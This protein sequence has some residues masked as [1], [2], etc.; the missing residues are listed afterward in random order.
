MKETVTAGFQTVTPMLMFGADQSRA[1]IRIPSIKGAL[2]FWYRAVDPHYWKHEPQ[3]FGSG[4]EKGGQSR[5]LMRLKTISQP[6]KYEK[7]WRKGVGYSYLSFSIKKNREPISVGTSFEISFY[8]RGH[9]D[10]HGNEEDWKRLMA[11]VWL[12]GHMGGLGSRSR[13]G[14]GSLTLKSIDPKSSVSEPFSL[15]LI[16]RQKKPHE[17]MHAFQSGMDQIQGWL[18]KRSTEP[19]HTVLDG[20][21]T[22]HLH[23]HGYHDWKLAM[24]ELGKTLKD[25]REKE[26]DREI[27]GRK[28]WSKGAAV[29]LPLIIKQEEEQK[30]FSPK[31][32]DR[33]ASP[34]WMR[35]VK[36]GKKYYPFVTV[37]STDTSIDQV[38]CRN[39]KGEEQPDQTL[40]VEIAE[41]LDAFRHH[42]QNQG[43]RWEAGGD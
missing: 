17:W 40:S 38:V 32:G 2:R 11:S 43:Y 36:I 28:K 25:F 9:L 12:L 16:H 5:F 18:G 21:S 19:K 8:R 29:G 13:R 1:E 14:F 4:G 10:D 23:M 37:L 34:I 26:G 33:N 35:I 6:E 20:K 39:E 15:P 31:K 22:F 41:T 27:S 7:K 3:L 30:T 24:D 42:L